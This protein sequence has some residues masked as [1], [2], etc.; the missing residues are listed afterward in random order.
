MSSLS[1]LGC[2]STVEVGTIGS[3]TYVGTDSVRYDVA[4]TRCFTLDEPAINPTFTIAVRWDKGNGFLTS[5]NQQQIIG[6]GV[7]LYE[8]QEVVSFYGPEEAVVAFP[9]V[10]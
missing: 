4:N 3:G 5:F 1:G 2:G 10:F 6:Q 9:L 8:G 7:V